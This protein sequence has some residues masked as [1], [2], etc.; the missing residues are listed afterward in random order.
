MGKIYDWRS[1]ALHDGVPFP[2]PMCQAPKKL[3]DG[4]EEFL[5]GVAASSHGGSWVFEDLPMLLHV[6][7]HIVRGTLLAWWRS[8]LNP[9]AEASST[10]GVASK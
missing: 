5:D 6:F 3:D 9:N 4:H 2:A 7:E 10:P 8:L 1:R